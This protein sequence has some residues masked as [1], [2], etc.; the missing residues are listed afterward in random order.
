MQD[1][2][3]QLVAQ[4]AKPVRSVIALGSNLGDSASIL[5]VAVEAFRKAPDIE[6]VAVSPRAKTAPVGGPE[7]PDFLNQVLIIQTSRSPYGLLEFG[8]KLEQGAVRVRDVRW[9]PR[10]LDVD[11]I[12]IDNVTSQHPVLTLPHPRAHEGALVVT[13]WSWADPGATVNG[14]PVAELA[15]RADDAATVHLVEDSR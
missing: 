14:V 11:L 6:I 10:T 5:D 2:D 4:P 8:H 12:D 13:P 9:G 7:Q 15:A 1:L 3:P